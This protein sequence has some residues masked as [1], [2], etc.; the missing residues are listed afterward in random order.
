MGFWFPRAATTPSEVVL[1]EA[2]ANTFIGRRSVGGK[3]AVTKE[4]LLF[5]P[6]RLDGLTGAREIAIPRSKIQ[7]VSIQESGRTAVRQRGLGAAV[8]RQVGV[9]HNG[10]TVFLTLGTSDALVEALR[11]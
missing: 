2:I 3:V 1:F 11:P 8:R 10:D 4:R 7:D 6:N 5:T 9:E